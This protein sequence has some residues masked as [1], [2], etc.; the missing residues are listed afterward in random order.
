MLFNLINMIVIKL[1]HCK[2]GDTGVINIFTPY[3]I[4]N[5]VLY[6]YINAI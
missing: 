6:L 2:K 5:T 4:N 3:N 1:Y